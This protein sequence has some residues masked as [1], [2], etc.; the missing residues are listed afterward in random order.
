LWADTSFWH[1]PD[2]DRPTRSG[3]LRVLF[4]GKVSLRKGVPYLLRAAASLGRDAALTLIGEVNDELRPSI[5]EYRANVQILARC[6]KSELR[7]HYQK[8]DVLVLPSLGDAF[9]FVALEAM[10][11]GL[12]VIV[13]ENCGVPVPDT[14]WRVPVM[15]SEAIADR[16]A[17]YAAD[18]DRCRADGIV[19]A[20]FARRYTP[21]RY[22]GNIKK[23]L[24]E[25][26]DP[27]ANGSGL[28][29][30]PFTRPR[31][32]ERPAAAHP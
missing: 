30:K 21:E 19:A 2:G 14:S 23:L 11:C 16:L 27:P 3:P 13:T 25:I 15:N 31:E 1:A 18:R 20:K 22:R 7:K 8:H 5:A 24:G 32:L 17:L 10:C 9:G 12:P 6:S 26:L 28:T 4:A 29:P